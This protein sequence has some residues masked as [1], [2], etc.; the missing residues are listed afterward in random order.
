MFEI[1]QSIVFSS[2]LEH[3]YIYIYPFETQNTFLT[4]YNLEVRGFK[5]VLRVFAFKCTLS[6]KSLKPNP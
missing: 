6:L 2:G 3:I 1:I 5:R 4:I